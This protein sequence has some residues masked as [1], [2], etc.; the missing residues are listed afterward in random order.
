MLSVYIMCWGFFKK[1]AF[2]LYVLKTSLC[3]LCFKW[4]KNNAFFFS[5]INYVT[6][7]KM[8]NC[9]SAVCVCVCD[10]IFFGGGGGEGITWPTNTNDTVCSSVATRAS[11]LSGR[12]D[13]G[14]RERV[15]QTKEQLCEKRNFFSLCSAVRPKSIVWR[16]TFEFRRK[17]KERKYRQNDDPGGDH[18][19][20]W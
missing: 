14:K 2:Y 11:H 3:C 9:P 1:E 5:T 18:G 10:G 4:K 6:I 12:E 15:R 20:L 19:A 8:I 13:K 16:K 17:E 7:N